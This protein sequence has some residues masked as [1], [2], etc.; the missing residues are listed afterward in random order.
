MDA[1]QVLVIAGA[2]LLS[3]AALLGFVQERHRDRPKLF[4][5]W[6][7]VH[8]GG[9]AGAVQLLALASLWQRLAGSGPGIERP[10]VHT[11][12]SGVTARF[13]GQLTSSPLLTVTMPR[14]DCLKRTRHSQ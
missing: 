1:T 4:A 12:G 14:S 7:V 8:S 3:I 9:T 11:C 10:C 2:I 13:R 5:A 6:R